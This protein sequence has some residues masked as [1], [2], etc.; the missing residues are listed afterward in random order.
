MTESLGDLK[1]LDFCTM[2]TF[3]G[4]QLVEGCLRYSYEQPW[5]WGGDHKTAKAAAEQ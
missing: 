5:G 4:Q 1:E 2:N 3:Q